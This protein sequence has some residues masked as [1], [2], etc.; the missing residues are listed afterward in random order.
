MLGLG[1]VGGAAV[2]VPI[3]LADG[4][5][6]ANML[7]ALVNGLVEGIAIGFAISARMTTWPSY[8]LARG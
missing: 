4:T 2:W 7:S 6:A 1:L 5:P 8:M 3:N